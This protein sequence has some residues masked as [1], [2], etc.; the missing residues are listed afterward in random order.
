VPN[1]ERALI[2]SSRFVVVDRQGQIRGYYYGTDWESLDRLQAN[3]KIV[4]RERPK[5][6]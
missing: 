1:A 6:R 2:H 5:E 4:L 3:V